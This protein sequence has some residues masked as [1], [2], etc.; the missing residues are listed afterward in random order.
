MGGE[1]IGLAEAIERVRALL[2]NPEETGLSQK[3]LAAVEQVV[4]ALEARLEDEQ[5]E[6][7]I[8]D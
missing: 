4:S 3:D 5:R 6:M 7:N 1:A 2:G 8:K